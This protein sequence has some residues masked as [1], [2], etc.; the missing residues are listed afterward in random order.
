LEGKTNFRGKTNL[1]VP[2]GTGKNEF[3]RGKTNFWEKTNFA[4]KNDFLRGKTNFARAFRHGY[5]LVYIIKHEGF[6]EKI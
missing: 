4:G 2:S 3:L 1:R 6:G 5:H